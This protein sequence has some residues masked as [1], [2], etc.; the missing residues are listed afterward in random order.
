MNKRI[1]ALMIMLTLLPHTARSDADRVM[2]FCRAVAAMSNDAFQIASYESGEFYTCRIGAKFTK[3][4]NTNFG[5]AQAA[6]HPF[7]NY[8]VL[9]FDTPEETRSAYERI[10]AHSSVVYADID[11]PMQLAKE[12]SE[13]TEASET[14]VV[15]EKLS[16]A[17]SFIGMDKYLSQSVQRGFTQ[18]VYVSVID[19]GIDLDHEYFAGRYAAGIDLVDNDME[20]NDTNGHGTHVCGIVAQSSTSNVKIVA[21]RVFGSGTTAS[22]SVVCAGVDAS[23]YAGVDVINM[24]IFGVHSSSRMHDLMAQAAQKN[25]HVCAAAGNTNDGGA[26]AEDICPAHVES[27]ITVTACSGAAADTRYSNYGDVCDIC[28][29]GT[30]ILSTSYNGGYTIKSGTSMASPMVAAACAMIKLRNPS[31]TCAQMEEKLKAWAY[32]PAGWDTKYGSGIM[33][34]PLYER[35]I[36]SVTQSGETINVRLSRNYPSD[37]AQEMLIT[38]V[39]DAQGAL[40]EVFCESADGKSEFEYACAAEQGGFAEAVLWDKASLWPLAKAK[41]SSD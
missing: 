36:V 24:S 28:A 22:S 17:V 3:H 30:D 34:L 1:V 5:A 27:V 12:A 20:P 23:I 11:Y 31:L 40:T 21:V 37:A 9:K 19:S 29:P 8:C 10:L 35:E 38:G 26:D 32:A 41:R 15:W 6:W 18:E 2:E 7:E 14:A 16:D 33:T 4:P 13:A 39:F 25:I